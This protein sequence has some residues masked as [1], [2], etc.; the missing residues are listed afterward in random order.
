[1]TKEQMID[2][3]IRKYGFEARVTIA[4]CRMCERGDLANTQIEAR[5]NELMKR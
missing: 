2:N 3:V 5:Y 4:F 1:M